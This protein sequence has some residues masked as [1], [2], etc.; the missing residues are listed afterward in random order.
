VIAPSPSRFL[1]IS[2]RQVIKLTSRTILKDRD[3]KPLIDE[4]TKIPGLEQVARKSRVETEEV[5]NSEIVIV[6]GKPLAFKRDGHLIPVLTNTAS[7]EKLPR[8]T[9]DMGA[10]PHVVGGADIMAPG[11]RKVQ[12]SFGENQLVVIIDEKHGKFLALGRALYS[13]DKFSTV[14]KGKV[15]ASLHYVGDPIWEAIKEMAPR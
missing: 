6:D 1:K 12:G 3:S 7:V 8:V 14:K 13:S 10:V 4:L 2:L 9:V 5:K 15:V 11:V